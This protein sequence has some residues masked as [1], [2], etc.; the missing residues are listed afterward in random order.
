MAGVNGRWPPVVAPDIASVTN[1]SRWAEHD[2]DMMDGH[3]SGK[4][5]PGAR[6]PK[7]QDFKSQRGAADLLLVNPPSCAAMNSKPYCS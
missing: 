3:P 5:A 6:M 1:N 2:F 7:L 4:Y